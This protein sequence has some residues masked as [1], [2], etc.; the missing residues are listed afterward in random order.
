MQSHNIRKNDQPIYILP[1]IYKIRDTVNR[2][3][4][5]ENVLNDTPAT[6]KTTITATNIFHTSQLSFTSYSIKKNL[7]SLFNTE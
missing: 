5:A 3:K 1:I 6:N 4:Q 2:R 7:T